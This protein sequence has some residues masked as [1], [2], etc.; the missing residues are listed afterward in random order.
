MQH[1]KQIIQ[2]SE[3]VK[4]K[5]RSHQPTPYSFSSDELDLSDTNTE[6]DR[7]KIKFIYCYQIYYS[8]K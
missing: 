1:H 4:N 8:F 3:H 6:N 5:I 2:L 7:G